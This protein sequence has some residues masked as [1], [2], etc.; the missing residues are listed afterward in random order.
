MRF[1]H[2]NTI[3]RIDNQQGPTAQHKELHAQYFVTIYKGK[4]SEKRIDTYT[5]VTEP[6]YCTSETN[7]TLQINDTSIQKLK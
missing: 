6:L 1:T 7:A 3:H 4:E 5:S 2:T